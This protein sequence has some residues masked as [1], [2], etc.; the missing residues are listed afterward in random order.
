MHGDLFNAF[1]DY[2]PVPVENSGS[3]PLLGQTFGVKD[4]IDVVGYP[5]GCGHPLKCR[6]SEIAR[7]NASCVQTVLD[8]GAVFVG[9]NHT[10]ELAYSL[11]GANHHYGTPIN[12]AA[13][14]RIPGGSSSGSAVA[15]AGKLACFSIGSDTGGSVRV[16]ASYCGIW[17]IRPTHGVIPMDGVM[18]FAPSFDTL[19]WFARDAA[20]LKGVGECLLPTDTFSPRRALIVTDAFDLLPTVLSDALKSAAICEHLPVGTVSLAEGGLEAWAENFRILQGYEIWQNHGDWIKQ[21]RPKFG[22]GIAERFSWTATISDE[23]AESA[24]Q[25]KA[26]FRRR[27][28]DICG[29]DTVL[30]LPTVPGPAPRR[31]ALVRD[32]EV[33]RNHALQV[34]CISGLSGFPQITYPATEKD[35]CPVGLS[36]LGPAGSD[37]GL[38]D[39]ACQ[40][41]KLTPA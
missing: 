37:R 29:D 13:P 30:L 7:Q 35:G 2:D 23:A 15:V 12:P 31:D 22:P 10:D 19:G 39:I 33:F 5:T 11:N 34:L 3:G 4:L 24:R 16:P 6:Q 36:I 18:P 8:A 1:V 14:D 20:T 40:L 27:L 41:R 9:K 32:L 17:G 25:A 38:L 26:D 21:F 28:A